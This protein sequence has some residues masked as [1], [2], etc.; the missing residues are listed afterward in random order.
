[1][2]GEGRPGSLRGFGACVSPGVEL[3]HPAF[4]RSRRC[5]QFHSSFASFFPSVLVGGGPYY[6][7]GH[8]AYVSADMTLLPPNNWRVGGLFERASEP[9]LQSP[10]LK[11]SGREADGPHVRSSVQHCSERSK[12]VG[13]SA[14][15][16]Y[17]DQQGSG[18]KREQRVYPGSPACISFSTPRTISISWANPLAF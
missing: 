2:Y 6:L 4:R 15:E 11:S 17:G 13:H 12:F 14:D 16:A 8:W 3:K 7:S 5:P 10:L 9:L 1:M 18:L